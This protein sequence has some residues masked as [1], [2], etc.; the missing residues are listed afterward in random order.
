MKL[1][2]TLN[3]EKTS[4]IVDIKL[5]SPR[6]G[7]LINRNDVPEFA[8]KMVKS[9]AAAVSVVTEEKY[10]NGNY[11]LLKEI[12]E[13]VD[14]PVIVKDFFN[15]V[16]KIKRAYNNG[17]DSVLLISSIL[18]KKTLKNLKTH[19]Q[20][21]GL[22]PLIETHSKNEIL[23]ANH[24]ETKLIGINNRNIKKLEMDSGNVSRT[25]KL[26][27]F[28]H[29]N[30]MIISE[31]SI[32]SKEDLKKIN[33]EVDAVMVGTSILTSNHPRNKVKELMEVNHG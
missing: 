25:K 24:L 29:D 28:A 31:S 1:F 32:E 10:F 12:R 18:G 27:K 9:G 16:R 23:R 5:R 20:K 2:N 7:D 6:D 13:V 4:L 3:S 8:E 21:L 26:A 22:E 19:C 30:A 11:D 15:E 14:V 33:S 17:A